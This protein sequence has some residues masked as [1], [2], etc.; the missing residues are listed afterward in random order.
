VVNN[1][2]GIP[3]ASLIKPVWGQKWKAS[4]YNEILIGP[5]R[6]PFCFQIFP[7]NTSDGTLCYRHDS[8]SQTYDMSG[9]MKGP[10]TLLEDL[11]LHSVVGDVGSKVIHQ[12]QHF[13]VVNKFPWYAAGVHQC[14]CTEVSH[15]RPDTL[16]DAPGEKHQPLRLTG[17]RGR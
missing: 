16:P 8:G 9:G 5:K 6:D 17:P 1:A 15:T 14:I 12:G 13:W 11:T 3:S 10:H 4:N 2:S 7:G